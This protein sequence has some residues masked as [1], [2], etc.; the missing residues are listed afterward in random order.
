MVLT[1]TLPAGVVVS[2]VKT[3]HGTIAQSGGVITVAF[4]PI[5]SGN[6]ES[7]TIT[8]V[9]LTP[10]VATNVASVAADQFN[11]L[12]AGATSSLDT[13]VAVN[14]VPPVIVSQR[15]VVGLRSIN[16]IVLTF[17]EPLDPLQATNAINYSL[18]GLGRGRKFNVPIALG[19]P[20][21]DA[22]AQT[23]TLTPLKPLPLAKVFELVINGHGSAGVTDLAGN[24]LIGNT[25]SAPLGPY[26]S[27]I[28]RGVIPPTPTAPRPARGGSQVKLV[29]SVTARRV[30]TGP[31]TTSATGTLLNNLPPLTENTGGQ[32]SISTL[33]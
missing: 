11:A 30:L 6:T 8:V 16:A 2:S 29:E 1:D 21:Y 24:L 17:N 18:L 3:D 15:L 26:V 5:E 20:V 10:G 13:G 12:P 33:G 14:G 32:N 27:L 25:P 23:V 4:G 9:P 7:V 31:A 19:V 28:S 22:K